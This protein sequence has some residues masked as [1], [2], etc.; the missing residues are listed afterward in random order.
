MAIKDI[1]QRNEELE[2][3]YMKA[4]NTINI[5]LKK[6]ERLEKENEKLRRE[7]DILLRAMK[8]AKQINDKQKQDL[9]IDRVLQYLKEFEEKPH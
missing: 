8:I 7:R 9:H 6:I 4:L 5:L 3:L 1:I 2:A